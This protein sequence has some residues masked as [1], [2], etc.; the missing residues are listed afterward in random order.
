MMLCADDADPDNDNPDDDN[1][2]NDGPAPDNTVAPPKCTKPGG[3]VHRGYDG[4]GS[5]G[6]AERDLWTTGERRGR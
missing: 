6:I 1:P 5:R 2:E 3:P 4:S